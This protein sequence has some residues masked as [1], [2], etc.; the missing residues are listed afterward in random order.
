MDAAIETTGI[1]SSETIVRDV[2][3]GLYEARHFFGQRLIEADLARRYGVSRGLIGMAV[4]FYENTIDRAREHDFRE[5][6]EAIFAG[7]PIPPTPRPDVMC[8]ASSK[9]SSPSRP[10]RSAVCSIP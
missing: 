10:M 6:V 2:V 1:S 9:R 7:A 3:Q 8:D 5:I 4:R